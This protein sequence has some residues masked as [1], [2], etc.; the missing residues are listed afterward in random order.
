[1]LRAT[2]KTLQTSSSGLH[3]THPY[4]H[5][6]R[7][8]CTTHAHKNNIFLCYGEN[9]KT[10]FLLQYTCT[11]ICDYIV[12]IDHLENFRIYATL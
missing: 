6:H 4:T 5:D 11:H 1:M 12:H 7:H 3:C 10:F 2:G 9:L 8:A